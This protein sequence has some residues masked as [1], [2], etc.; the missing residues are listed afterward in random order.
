MYLLQFSIYIHTS[1]RG[2]HV[3]HFYVYVCTYDL[4]CTYVVW[5]IC[6][7]SVYGQ[8]YAGGYMMLYTTLYLPTQ[9]AAILQP[10]PVA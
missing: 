4:V 9:P 6:N 7:Q 10:T 1:F 3:E 2:Y 5:Y 8:M